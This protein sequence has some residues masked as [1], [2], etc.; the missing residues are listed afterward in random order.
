MP[1]PSYITIFGNHV[2]AV[3]EMPDET[4]AVDAWRFDGGG[5][6]FLNSQPTGLP[7][8]RPD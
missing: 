7:G 4:E 8:F 3:S 1:N 5:F 2:W 6:T